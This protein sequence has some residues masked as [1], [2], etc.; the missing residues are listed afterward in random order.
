MKKSIIALALI[1]CL[2]G[3]STV[4]A[5]NTA[6][7]EAERTS[8]AA[9]QTSIN[10]GVALLEN[11]RA[12]VLASF[13]A[14]NA[15]AWP[16]STDALLATGF[17]SNITS[18]WGTKVLGAVTGG[19]NS[20]TLNLEAPVPEVAT[21]IG[22]RLGAAVSGNVVSLTVPIPA[23]ASIMDNGLMRY[24]VAGRPELNQ[25]QTDIDMNGFNLLNVNAINVQ[26]VNG[27]SGTLDSLVVNNSLQVL[28][29]AVFNKDVNVAGKLT[30]NE[31]EAKIVR[32]QSLIVDSAN[33]NGPLNVVD[34]I[35]TGT[36]N[37]PTVNTQRLSVDSATIKVLESDS[38]NLKNAS[39]STLNAGDSYITGLLQVMKNAEFLSD[40]RFAGSVAVDG[41][42][43][44]A[45]VAS[46]NE[47]REG[48]LFLRE[49][50]LGIN[51]TAKDSEKL[52]GVQASSYARKD[53]PNVF[54]G[55]QTFNNGIVTTG[56]VVNGASTH[57]G[58][59]Y[60]NQGVSVTGGNVDVNGSYD[61]KVGSIS[62]KD[63]ANRLRNLENNSAGSGNKMGRWVKLY[64]SN[65]MWG[66]DG[67]IALYSYHNTVT[68]SC[69]VGM[70]GALKY[71]EKGSG[72]D[73]SM[74]TR[75]A[76]YE[77]R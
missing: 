33:I 75:Y 34:V 2:G 36:V 49:K 58:R 41:A 56:L 24:A 57:N 9:R 26:T 62:V 74:E 66:S 52:G 32:G 68:G 76:I 4:S 29:D 6:S 30:A 11:V 42:L 77:C 31:L 53:T 73:P 13:M 67:K 63:L 15:N 35:A 60:A 50:Y 55:L 1:G 19:G 18:A 16:A 45:Q 71:S 8:Y 51:S 72:H 7:V 47:I 12:A 25:M 3:V 64:E 59:I 54:N 10:N 61:V 40:V 5:D 70:Q 28:S 17:T 46:I 23:T 21:G 38:A 69:V 65:S 14:N 44:V 22:G 43:T 37:A 39:I 48:G 27:G 20:F